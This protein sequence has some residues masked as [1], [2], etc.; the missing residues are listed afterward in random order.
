VARRVAT[1][2]ARQAKPATQTRTAT[3]LDVLAPTTDEAD[4]AT[5]WQVLLD[6]GGAEVRRAGVAS[7]YNPVKGDVVVVARYLNTLFV[8]DRVTAG[9]SG[10]EPGGRVGYAYYTG[11]TGTFQAIPASTETTVTGLVCSVALRDGGAYQVE[12]GGLGVHCNVAN[13][14]TLFRLRE[15]GPGGLD[16]G[17]WYRLPTNGAGQVHGFDGHRIIRNDNGV[18]L[19]LTIALTAQPPATVTA[20]MF[21]TAVTRPFIEVTVKGSSKLYPHAAPVPPPPELT[22]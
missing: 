20:S 7:S 11:A 4:V 19:T 9:D 8:I 14:Q 1:S 5:G 3:V 10:G 17:E 16:L 22:T 2:I 15:N 18:D 6:F 12:I 13:T 21:C